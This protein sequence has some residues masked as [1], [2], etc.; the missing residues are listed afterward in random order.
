M[1]SSIAMNSAPASSISPA[2]LK[3]AKI[4]HIT[5]CTGL[6]AAMT[7]SAEAMTMAEKR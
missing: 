3:K 5:L 2:A 6:R 1:T 4:N 7:I